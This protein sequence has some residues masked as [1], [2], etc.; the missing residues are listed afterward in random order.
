MKKVS[1]RIKTVETFEEKRIPCRQ[2]CVFS[3]EE[4]ESGREKRQ[5]TRRHLQ[6]IK[7]PGVRKSSVERVLY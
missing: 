3:G 5:E 6:I 4:D 2:F 1:C 7:T